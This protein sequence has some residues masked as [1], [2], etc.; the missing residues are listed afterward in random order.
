MKNFEYVLPA[1]VSEALAF[2]SEKGAVAKAGGIDLLDIVKE[3]LAAPSRLVNIG[4]LK[5][6]AFIRPGAEGGLSIGPAVT[7]A[8]LSE[9]EAIVE[10]P[11][12][13]LA[14]AAAAAATPQIRNMATVAGNL[15]QRPR[16]WYFRSRDF[17]CTRKGGAQCFALDGENPYHAIF[18]NEDGC[19]IV[20]PSAVAVVLLALDARLKIKDE[21]GEAE[22]PIAEFF[23]APARDIT[24]EHSLKEGQLIVEIVLPPAPSGLSSYYLKQKEKQSFDW[25]IAEAVAALQLDGKH[26]KEARVVLGAAAPIPWRATK[27]EELL[28]GKTVTK[29]LARQAAEAVTADARPL[30]QNAYKVPVFKAVIARTICVAAGIDPFS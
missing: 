12:R 5:E 2:L 11:F 14:Q 21:K 9:N 8:A 19:V 15:C 27:A 22:V 17:D 29:E 4:S 16:C 7:L 30:S 13:A 24:R 18:G 23:V 25:P 10:G 1:S 26:V 20:H 3:G 6:L 28:K